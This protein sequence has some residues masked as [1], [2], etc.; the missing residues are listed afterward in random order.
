MEGLNPQPSVSPAPRCEGLLL[1]G[2]HVLGALVPPLPLGCGPASSEVLPSERR[3]LQAPPGPSH[4]LTRGFPWERSGGVGDRGPPQ[5]SRTAWPQ[6]TD[7]TDTGPL[8]DN[9][10]GVRLLGSF[11]GSPSDVKMRGLPGVES[12]VCAAPGW[13]SGDQEGAGTGLP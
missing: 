10:L 9:F 4:R 8:A 13:G 7:V 2:E 6:A 1:D 12:R 3:T 5:T 11:D